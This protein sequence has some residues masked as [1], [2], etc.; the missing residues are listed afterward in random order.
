M[1]RA[2]KNCDKFLLFLTIV[3]SLYG[4][5]NL[6]TASSREAVTHINGSMFY[7]FFRHLEIHQLQHFQYF[8]L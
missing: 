5:F 6:V 2:L 7:Y 3:F 4:L 8:P 1:K